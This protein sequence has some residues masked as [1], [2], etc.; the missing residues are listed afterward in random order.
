M[1]LSLKT[2]LVLAISGMVLALVS[3]LSYVYLSQLLRQRVTEAFDDGDI[4]AH[5]IYQVSRDAMEVD[6][7]NLRVDENNPDDIRKVIENSLREDPG[8][9][10]LI[11]SIVGYQPSVYEV[12]IADMKGNALLHSVSDLQGKPLPQREP[13]L[14]LRKANFWRL[15]KV[16]YGKPDV[17][18]ITLDLKRGGIPFGQIRVSMQ[19]LFLK[20]ELEPQFN[21][22]L[23]FAG[24][25]IL[26]SFM[27]AAALSNFALRP[28]EVIGERLDR[29]T[30]GE[31]DLPVEEAEPE[32][33]DEYGVVSTKID[34]LGRQMRDV[35]E[36]FSAL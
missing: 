30:A 4:I 22:A 19:T 35:K 13:F 5:Q 21:R 29:M 25:A 10:S 14:N 7:S 18:D 12:A 6:I 8:V 2:K 33:R 23:V 3:V 17:Y 9:N 26:V 28:L 15:A 16:V 24:I 11:Q 36:V 20:N 32:R 1:R 31:I 34:R 27:L